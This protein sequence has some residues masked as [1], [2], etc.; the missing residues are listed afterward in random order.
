MAVNAL[1]KFAL[2]AGVLAGGARRLGGELLEFGVQ[3][4]GLEAVLYQVVR[5][6]MQ[7]R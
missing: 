2:D 7:K 4:L 5:R 6:T 1:C 3:L